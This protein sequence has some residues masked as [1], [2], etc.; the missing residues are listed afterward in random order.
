[1]TALPATGLS[2]AVVISCSGPGENFVGAPGNAGTPAGHSAIGTPTCSAPVIEN[3]SIANRGKNRI[4]S[5][6][7]IRGRPEDQV[8][9][10]RNDGFVIELRR[11]AELFPIRIGEECFPFRVE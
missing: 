10:V 2:L 6:L 5:N 7:R 8:G 3:A 1:M 4:A 11:R 9:D